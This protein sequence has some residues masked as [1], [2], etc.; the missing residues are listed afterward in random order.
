MTCKPPDG[1][2]CFVVIPQPR[3]ELD[4]NFKKRNTL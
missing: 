1:E 4:P 2:I 3:S